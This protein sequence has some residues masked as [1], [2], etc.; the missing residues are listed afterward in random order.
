MPISVI[1]L[2]FG[3]SLKEKLD[4]SE[5]QTS[6]RV[7][8]AIQDAAS[9]AKQF[10]QNELW[11][12]LDSNLPS[13]SSAVKVCVQSR[14]LNTLQF[15]QDNLN[16]WKRLSKVVARGAF[17]LF[18]AGT[19]EWESK[20][21]YEPFQ[22]NGTR[23][24]VIVT[25]DART[26]WDAGLVA[27][28]KMLALE[29]FSGLTAAA[30]G[31]LFL[32]TH[33]PDNWAKVV[34]SFGFD[35]WWLRIVHLSIERNVD[36]KIGDFALTNP[37]ATGKVHQSIDV[38]SSIVALKVAI[39]YRKRHCNSSTFNSAELR[40]T[41][42]DLEQAKRKWLHRP[43]IRKRKRCE[44]VADI[45]SAAMNSSSLKE[46]L[47]VRDVL[48]RAS[49]ERHALLKRI[50]LLDKLV[51]TSASW[52][53]IVLEKQNLLQTVLKGE[54]ALMRKQK[55]DPSALVFKFTTE[56]VHKKS[57]ASARVA[58][59]TAGL[60]ID[61]NDSIWKSQHPSV[62]KLVAV[63]AGD[64]TAAQTVYV[65]SGEEFRELFGNGSSGTCGTHGTAK[66]AIVEL[67][68]LTDRLLA[69]L[70]LE[71]KLRSTSSKACSLPIELRDDLK[72]G[73]YQPTPKIATHV[74]LY[75]RALKIQLAS[76]KY[77]DAF[78]EAVKQSVCHAIKTAFFGCVKTISQ[79]QNAIADTVTNPR[80]RAALF[81]V[82]C[83]LTTAACFDGLTVNNSD[84]SDDDCITII[85]YNSE[86]HVLT[87]PDL[88]RV[89][90]QRWQG[91]R[92]L[93]DISKTCEAWL[94]NHRKLVEDSTNVDWWIACSADGLIVSQA[95]KER[96][97]SDLNSGTSK[98][99]DDWPP[100]REQVTTPETI[101]TSIQWGGRSA[102]SFLGIE[103]PSQFLGTPPY[104][105]IS[106]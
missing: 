65:R 13:K 23:S 14:C 49:R 55:E 37:R 54:I 18:S 95:H 77:V 88:E 64:A 47:P 63:G 62:L 39:F 44:G 43:Q 93:A 22:L 31:G 60:A 91:A 76:S 17:A 67:Q 5:M 80:Q 20:T 56:F 32:L 70:V 7:W 24:E 45:V 53:R 35:Y 79:Q 15:E 97:L 34:D 81:I 41:R 106:L 19:A 75:R 82:N 46:L 73:A 68:S 21:P 90:V 11:K 100:S 3:K 38:V 2:N 99:W 83:M 78:A 92:A 52:H 10:P 98:W 42:H 69:L 84:D 28:D 96:A 102:A 12:V 4:H 59:E 72:I 40:V 101:A 71:F 66:A 36:L 85:S 33:T 51:C 89:V 61:S 50:G 86:T 103:K 16:E 74:D 87:M 26:A 25:G 29:D 6:Q 48:K 58:V 105:G 8:K 104:T 30:M 94:R 27:H 57:I 1:V 9:V